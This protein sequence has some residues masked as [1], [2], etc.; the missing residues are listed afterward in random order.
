MTMLNFDLTTHQHYWGNID[1]SITRNM[2]Y[3]NGN[4]IYGI[5]NAVNTKWFYHKLNKES[6]LIFKKW[7]LETKYIKKNNVYQNFTNP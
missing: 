5:Q 4:T 1:F 2:G 7:L 6:E 3:L